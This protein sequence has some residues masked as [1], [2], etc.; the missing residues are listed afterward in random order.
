LIG[1]WCVSNAALGGQ[2][3]LAVNRAPP[4]EHAV[5]IPKTNRKTDLIDVIAGFDLFRDTG[6]QVH[7]CDRPVVHEVYVFEKGDFFAVGH[8]S[9]RLKQIATGALKFMSCNCGL[10]SGVWRS[11]I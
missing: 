3:V 9:S 11:E 4:R 10:V 8:A 5:P 2:P 1:I 7:R 6:R